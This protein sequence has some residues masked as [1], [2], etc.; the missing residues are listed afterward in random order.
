MKKVVLSILIVLLLVLVG[1]GRGPTEQREQENYH[2]GIRGIEMEFV[3]NAPP[4]RV[5]EGDSLDISIR[6]KNRGAYPVSETLKGKLE[7]SGFDPVSING[8]WDGGNW[9]PVDLEGRN[10]FN[11]EGGEDVMA[12]RDRDGVHVPFDADYYEPTILVHSC[13]EYKTIADPIVCIDPD[14][15]AIVEERKVCYIRD[16]S[17]GRGEGGGQG[18]PIAV[19]SVEEEVGSDQIYFRIYVANLG[20]GSVMLPRAY[21]DCPF[22]VEFEDLDKITAKV[23]LP[24][25]ASPDCTP[26]GTASDPIWLRNG[27]GFIFCKFSKPATESA[28]ETTLNVELE[29]VYSSSI[30]KQIKIINLK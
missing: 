9:M 18:A 22:D 14:P 28:Y 16:I 21:N 19:T 24:Y 17:Y 7:I 6:L 20:G 3:R 8:V 5:Y 13:Y 4:Y 26:K 2:T 15:Y 12:Y 25:D 27:R 11:P 10:Q 29:Y 1:C 30:Y 23:K